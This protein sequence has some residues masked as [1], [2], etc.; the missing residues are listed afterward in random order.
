ME[1]NKKAFTQILGVSRDDMLELRGLLITKGPTITHVE[2][3]KLTDK[4]GC[5]RIYTSKDKLESLEHW[6][7]ANIA[8]LVESLDMR[9]PVPGFELP[10]CVLAN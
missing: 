8:V 7:K 3:T 5:W 2:P 6:L 4:Q 1:N 10:H 9:S